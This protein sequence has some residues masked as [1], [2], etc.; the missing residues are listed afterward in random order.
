M[1]FKQNQQLFVKNQ[2][3]SAIHKAIQKVDLNTMTQYKFPGSPAAAQAAS[4]F[5]YVPVL[6]AKY[7]KKWF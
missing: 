4:E 5:K 1:R 6:T 7:S 2:P 3:I